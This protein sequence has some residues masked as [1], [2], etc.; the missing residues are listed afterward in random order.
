MLSIGTHVRFIIV[1]HFYLSC[2]LSYHFYL[3]N[4][5]TYHFTI[6]CHTI[7]LMSL[8][9][10][11]VTY[12]KYYKVNTCITYKTINADKQKKNTHTKEDLQNAKY[13]SFC[14][15]IT[16][17]NLKQKTHRL[18][19]IFFNRQPQLILITKLKFKWQIYVNTSSYLGY[20]GGHADSISTELYFLNFT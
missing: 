15:S 19:I 4:Y 20:I 7:I 13:D 10:V 9:G 8:I 1:Y 14:L 3:Y 12:N 18:K 17:H 11:L 2:Y 6:L 16:K 5:L